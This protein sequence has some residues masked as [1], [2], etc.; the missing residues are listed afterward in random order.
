M[1]YYYRLS[2]MG[3]EHNIYPVRC[4][5]PIYLNTHPRV[6]GKDIAI[7]EI[8]QDTYERMIGVANPE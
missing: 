8:A 3:A 1:A 5:K 6:K 2:V 4:N 7:C